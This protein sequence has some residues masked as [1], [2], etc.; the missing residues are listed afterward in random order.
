MEKTKLIIL[1]IIKEG[2]YAF[3]YFRGLN[4]NKHTVKG[5]NNK[6]EVGECV[7]VNQQKAAFQISFDD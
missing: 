4:Q 5:S 3:S 2:I 6:I 1:T 7:G